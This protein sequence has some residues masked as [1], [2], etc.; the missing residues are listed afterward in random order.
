MN[1][2]PLLLL[3]P[4]L[5]AA[6]GGSLLPKPPAAST[7]YTLD[8]GQAAPGAV[9]VPTGP[10][11]MLATPHALP[12][13][14]S[15]RM[16]Y[17]RQHQV[18]ESYS[19]SEWLDTPVQML[20]PLLMR[21]LQASAAFSAV[22]LAPSSARADWQLELELVR[23]LQDFT[24]APSRSRLTL[25][26]V[27]LD[28]LTRKVIGAREFDHSVAAASED[29]AGGAYAAQQ[30]ALQTATALARFCAEPTKRPA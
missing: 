19:Q 27:L 24:Q 14:D 18:L 1:R 30:A 2:R 11:L 5:L 28:S 23:L 16:L 25:R 26:A 8:D 10:V 3:T 15:P 4:A 20:A 13:F 12:G 21:A 22:L 7:R 17:Q 9:R 6:C 29:A